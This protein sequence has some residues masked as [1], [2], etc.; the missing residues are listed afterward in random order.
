MLLNEITE[1][2]SIQH[3]DMQV[4]VASYDSTCIKTLNWFLQCSVSSMLSSLLLNETTG[5]ASI[6]HIDMPVK[7][8]SYDSTCIEILN[9]YL[10]CSVNITLSRVCC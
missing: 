1:Y 5:C 8:A 4:K 3:V 9:R 6:Q 7:V 2:A 10:L